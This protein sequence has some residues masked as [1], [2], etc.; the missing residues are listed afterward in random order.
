MHAQRG[1]VVG[2]ASDRGWVEPAVCG[3]ELLGAAGGFIHGLLAGWLVNVIED[4]PERGFDLVLDRDRCLGDDVTAAMDQTP[5]TQA[6]RK[7]GL[8]CGDQARRPVGDAQ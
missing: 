4:R 5:L 1:E 3:G 7:R 2:Q 6:C 8:P